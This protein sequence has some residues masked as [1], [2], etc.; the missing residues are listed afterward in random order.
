MN[1]PWVIIV[2]Q[3]PDQSERDFRR[4]GY[5]THIT[6]YR[7]MLSPHGVDRRC[8]TAM[9]SLF[10]GLVFVQDWRGWPRHSISGEPRLMPNAAGGGAPAH[11]G[12]D[13]MMRLICDEWKGDFDDIKWPFGDGKP[14][15][16]QDLVV[17]MELVGEKLGMRI[18]GTLA[19]LSRAGK[20]TLLTATGAVT[21]DASE[22]T[23]A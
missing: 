22:L 14:I 5:R 12:D 17:G 15:V 21:I 9:R 23:P 2:S 7:R 3:S 16:R 13:D 11:L 10:P 8:V 6:R 4:A 19:K 1:A 18:V 20:A